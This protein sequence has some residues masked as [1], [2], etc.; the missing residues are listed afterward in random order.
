MF[1][2]L[3]F[4]IFIFLLL[5]MIKSKVKCLLVMMV[6]QPT[7]D[8]FRIVGS[9]KSWPLCACI[10]MLYT[11]STKKRY[12]SFPFK[13]PF[14]FLFISY[15]LSFLLGEYNGFTAM[16]PFLGNLFLT[17]L[18]WR[19]FEPTIS[20]LRFLIILGLCYYLV[21]SLYGLYEGVTFSYPFTEWIESM[22]YSRRHGTLGEY[23]R[24]GFARANSFAIYCTY[25]AN[26][27]GIGLVF[28]TFLMMYS[29]KIV[30][31]KL[32]VLF[33]VFI[34]LG[35]VLISGDRSAM[36]MTSIFMLSLIPAMK[37][38]KKW[39]ML[40]I[41]V[42]IAI[43]IQLSEYFDAI[44][45]ALAHTEEVSGSNIDM[46]VGQLDAAL[47]SFWESPIWGHGINAVGEIKE[48]K[49]LGLKGGESYIFELLVNY[50]VVGI[51]AFLFLIISSIITLIHKRAII[52]VPIL[53]GFMTYN[54]LAL[55]VNILYIFPFI[56]I[57][58][59]TIIA[60]RRTTSN[61]L[62]CKKTEK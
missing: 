36:L 28:M 52:I 3:S 35:G 31:P 62:L 33:F 27:C 42:C 47:E 59:K 41:L 16:V 9:I 8:V 29:N 50:G 32:F 43:Y 55:P 26:A 23:E 25:F 30:V 57:L 22:D 2:V 21:L 34:M 58:Y 61:H 15:L 1:H 7:F 12:P 6:V 49:N 24:F 17:I 53:I 39:V 13:I 19:L 56:V 38:N 45:F 44:Y 54:I 10:M 37:S 48:H 18:L 20:N 11:Y 14:Y 60:E 46:R 51:M 4:T 40:A 5:L